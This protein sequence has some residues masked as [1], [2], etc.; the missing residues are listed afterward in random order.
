MNVEC[1]WDEESIYTLS[2]DEAKEYH[3][4]EEDL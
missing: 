4:Y 1:E 3:N 2:D